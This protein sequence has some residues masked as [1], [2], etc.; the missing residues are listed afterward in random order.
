MAQRSAFRRDYLVLRTCG[1]RS[2]D[3]RDWVL[4]TKCSW[5]R[6]VDCPLSTPKRKSRSPN[7]SFAAV[8]AIPRLKAAP[9]VAQT[10]STASPFQNCP[11]HCF[12]AVVDEVVPRLVPRSEMVALCSYD[13]CSC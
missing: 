8:E 7:L 6:A 1:E 5:I 12:A 11:R 4:G 10:H 3:V 2:A 13:A 9:G